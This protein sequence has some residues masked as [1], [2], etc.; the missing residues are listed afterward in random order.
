MQYIIRAIMK[1]MIY[2]SNKLLAIVN[3]RYHENAGRWSC[4][5]SSPPS[6][7]Y[8]CQW[9]GSALVEIMARHLLGTEP[10]SEPMM[11]YCQL[12]PYEQ[13]SVKF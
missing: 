6:A 9:I 7:A 10:L 2:T 8:M 5:N 12:G 11:D 1:T 4:F 13:T 3:C